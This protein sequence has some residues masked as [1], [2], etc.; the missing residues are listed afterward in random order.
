M[1]GTHII[2]FLIAV[3]FNFFPPG[4]SVNKL[5][6]VL[7]DTISPLSKDLHFATIRSD[8]RIMI[9]QEW[10]RHY[11][12]IGYSLPDLCSEK[13]ILFTNPAME[14]IEDP[15]YRWGAYSSTSDLTFEDCKFIYRKRI[16]DFIEVD[17]VG[18]EHL[19][20]KSYMLAKWFRSIR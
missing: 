19:I 17:L 12:I 5:Q 7:S 2:S 16:G 3:S 14:R 18:E 11:W 1:A 20:F 9:Q 15:K 8:G 13:L 4:G 10:V 6:T